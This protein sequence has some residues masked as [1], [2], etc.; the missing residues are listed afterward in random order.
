PFRTPAVPW[1]PLFGIGFSL[2]L[3]FGLPLDT[4]LR[5]VVWLVVG[6][7]IYF[8]YGHRRSLVPEPP[9]R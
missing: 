7:A 3:M 2:L 8:G 5:L 6:L 4:W 9:A 1:V